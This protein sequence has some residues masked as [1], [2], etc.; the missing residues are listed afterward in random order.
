MQDTFFKKVFN[1]IKNLRTPDGAVRPG[2]VDGSGTE[3][4][5]IYVG[6]DIELSHE[7]L[8]AGER[9]RMCRTAARTSSQC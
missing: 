4:D 2:R 5:P 1:S 8:L 7:H 6:S 3:D 9:I